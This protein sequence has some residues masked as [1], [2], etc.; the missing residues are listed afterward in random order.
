MKLIT[1]MLMPIGLGLLLGACASNDV[2]HQVSTSVAPYSDYALFTPVADIPDT[3]AIHTL[4]ERQ[5]T[6]FLSYFHDPQ[7]ADLSRHRRVA[8]FITSFGEV[9][10]FYDDTLTAT[11]TFAQQ[12]G[13]CLSLAILTTALAELVDVEVQFQQVESI[14]VY[15]LEGATAL[16]QQHVRSFI[17]T[18]TTRAK[19]G[20]LI[21]RPAG[22]TIDYFPS[23]DEVFVGNISRNQYLAMFYRNL[24]AEALVEQENDRSFALLQQ[25]LLLA[26]E[27]PDGLN[28]MG[29]LHRRVGDT[30]RAEKIYLHAIAGN[31]DNVSL[32]KNY[33]LLL[34]AQAREQEAEQ[35]GRQLLA[36]E[37]PSPVNWL[38]A[39]NAAFDQGD[40]RQARALYKRASSLAPY[41]HDG[42][43]GQARSSYMLG[44]I[45]QAE[46]MLS[47]AREYATDD[48]RQ[49]LYERKL[50]AL[51]SH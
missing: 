15:S 24:A 50:S 8:D 48:Q 51:T 18:P 1:R 14:P 11:N 38:A 37:D 7:R 10:T 46:R 34:A 27:H 12:R 30:L 20:S 4:D 33:Q 26:P 9:F 31:P 6:E 45:D 43:F 2:S 3:T 42:Y 13:N 35:L 5:R 39:G 21:L 28:M 49:R 19:V 23:G 44:E 32:L 47:R 22:V 17:Y 36:L 40:Y 25:S 41:M 16:K 29:V